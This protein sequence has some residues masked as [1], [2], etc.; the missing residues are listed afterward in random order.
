MKRL[1]RRSGSFWF[2]VVAVLMLASGIWA[3]TRF[4]GW[5]H[6]DAPTELSNG[7]TLRNVGLLVGGLLAFVFA[8]WRA[9]VA[10]QQ[11]IAAQ[12]Q[13]E[14]TLQSLLYERCQRGAE[15]LGSRVLAVRMGG[16]YALKRLA[17]EYPE[18]F[19]IQ[20]MELLSAFVRNP[21]GQE[22]DLIVGN[23]GAD[24][25]SRLREDIQAIMTAIGDRSEQ[26]IKLEEQ[27]NYVPDLT[28]AFLCHLRLEKANLCSAVFVNADLRGGYL[29]DT[30]I[31]NANL[32]YADLTGSVLGFSNLSHA[33]L[34]RARLCSANLVSADLTGA[35]L[36]G[37]N[38]SNADLHA[39]TL[40][41]ATFYG[42]QLSGTDF[43]F[44]ANGPATGMTQFQLNCTSKEIESPPK[45]ARVIDAKTGKRLVWHQDSTHD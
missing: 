9:W 17:D 20:V 14:T 18:Q 44:N 25:G 8:G 11:A 31:S 37:A 15:M 16:I 21:G 19:Y 30:N 22:V 33:T 26:R 34:R 1:F 29:H 23:E 35:T 43:S 28:G 12:R 7:E 13:A 27:N 45:L 2:V 5:L 38:L 24:P 10:E 41:N 3:S 40:T 4:W 36:D 6:P 32:S 42:A 39:T